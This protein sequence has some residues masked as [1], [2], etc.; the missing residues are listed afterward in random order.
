MHL[1][2]GLGPGLGF[3]AAHGHV[4]QLV[5]GLCN[6]GCIRGDEARGEGVGEGKAVVGWMQVGKGRCANKQD[7]VFCFV[8]YP[9]CFCLSFC[10][11]ML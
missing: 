10:V 9:E 7:Q 6:K 1:K 2:S 4:A 8:V 5:V 3:S 11:R